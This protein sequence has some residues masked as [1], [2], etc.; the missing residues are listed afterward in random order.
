MKV[1][2]IITSCANKGPI[3]MVHTLVNY[4]NKAGIKCSV[5][6]F[7]DINE[8]VFPCDT[9]RIS[10]FERIDFNAYAIIHAHLFRPDLYCA[11]HSRKIDKSKAKII[12]TIHTAIYDDLKY[13]YGKL[14]SRMFIPFWEAAWKKMDHTVLLTT[15][16]K[17]YYLKTGFN[18]V[19]VIANGRDLPEEIEVI[20][21]QD[22][23][24]IKDLKNK[25]ILMGTVC[26]M[27]SRK[28]LEQILELLTLKKDYAF[29]VVGDGPERLALESLALEL[30]VEKRFKVL[31]FRSN[32]YRYL[33]H[34]DFYVLPSRSEG[35]PL[36]LLEAMALKVPAVCAR[37]PSL[38]EE[39]G[40]AVCYF[41]A[42][43]EVEDLK[44]ACELLLADSGSKAENA[45][46]YYRNHY[47]GVQMGEKYHV[48]YKS[49]LQITNFTEIQ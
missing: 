15:A 37:I 39:F 25:F 46:N 8:L 27:D 23:H 19:S 9:K 7:D 30:G 16:A 33:P 28:G 45:F 20:E 22:L 2:F 41:F 12:T 4:L 32:G 13:T 47:T 43:D 11:Y 49:M 24:L 5:Y 1:A 29:I 17:K 31:G 21:A 18:E 14:I 10:F 38:E 34:F 35:M 6:Y 3:I 26:S 36:A 42:L 40:D 44:V 48:L